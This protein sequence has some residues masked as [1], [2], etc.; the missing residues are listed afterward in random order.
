MYKYKCRLIERLFCREN[1]ASICKINKSFK[2]GEVLFGN[3]LVHI[4][5]YRA[6][7][8]AAKSLYCKILDI[9]VEFLLRSDPFYFLYLRIALNNIDIDLREE[10][11]LAFQ[12]I[13]C[14]LQEFLHKLSTCGS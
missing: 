3:Q 13:E 10:C 9:V 12:D 7:V 4:S 8:R 11:F 6:E 2:V 1:A 14:L 5:E